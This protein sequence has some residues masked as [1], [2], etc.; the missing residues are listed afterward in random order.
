M[1][2][3]VC[4]SV[5]SI[6]ALLYLLLGWIPYETASNECGY[7]M[8]VYFYTIGIISSI[9]LSVLVASF[10]STN[11]Y[12]YIKKNDCNDNFIQYNIW[13]LV[14]FSVLSILLNV[15]Y[16]IWGAEVLSNNTCT[17]YI[18]DTMITLTVFSGL[19]TLFG[20]AVCT[21]MI[22]EKLNLTNDNKIVKDITTNIETQLEPPQGLEDHSGHDHSNP[23]EM[24]QV[25]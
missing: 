4:F 6:W 8:H 1:M 10:I 15:A 13:G 22:V 20:L 3:L 19:S 25:S 2:Y 23:E 12:L 5:S 16:F 18:E 9:Q 21:L 7:N 24:T 17:R 11:V 14:W